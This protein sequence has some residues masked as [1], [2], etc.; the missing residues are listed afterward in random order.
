M[1][2]NQGDMKKRLVQFATEHLGITVHRFEKSC[3]LSNSYCSNPN[4][5][6]SYA[7]KKIVEAYPEL[8]MDWVITGNGSMLKGAELKKYNKNIVEENH[9]TQVKEDADVY[10]KMNEEVVALKRELELYKMLYEK[11]HKDVKDLSEQVGAL[12]AEIDNLKKGENC[13]ETE[14]VSVKKKRKA[15]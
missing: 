9:I 8:N 13:S 15:S 1:S 7:K 6:G 4:V 2:G 12:K 10:G 14:S 11:E 3:G 5:V